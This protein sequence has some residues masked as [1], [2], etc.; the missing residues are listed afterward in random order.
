MSVQCEGNTKTGNRC[1]NRTK[2]ESKRCHLHVSVPKTAEVPQLQILSE[3][4]SDKIDCCVCM[5]E[6]PSTDKLKCTHPVCRTCVGKLRSDKCPM[7]RREIAAH[8]L[9]PRQKSNMRRRF[10]QDRISRN[11]EATNRAIHIF[12]NNL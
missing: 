9:K 2:H 8:Y 5:D 7:C 6:M 10:E 1:K 3:Q 4:S 11:I 12:V